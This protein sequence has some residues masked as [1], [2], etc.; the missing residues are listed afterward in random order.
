M[1]DISK[2]VSVTAETRGIY[3]EAAVP[4]DLSKSLGISFTGKNANGARIIEFTVEML[5]DGTLSL[6]L[7]EGGGMVVRLESANSV[8]IGGHMHDAHVGQQGV[9]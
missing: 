9:Y 2:V 6:R 7:T 8:R 4:I 3:P 5:E 1:T